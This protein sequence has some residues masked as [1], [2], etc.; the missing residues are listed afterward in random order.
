MIL[1]GTVCMEKKINFIFQR[2]DWESR[3]THYK[4]PVISR[5]KYD[6]VLADVISF[7]LRLELCFLWG[8]PLC[9]IS[10]RRAVNSNGIEKILVMGNIATFFR[11]ELSLIKCSS[12]TYRLIV[13]QNVESVVCHQFHW[14]F[15]VNLI[16]PIVFFIGCVALVI[17]PIIG[18]PKDTGETIVYSLLFYFLKQN[19]F[20]SS[21]KA[22][23]IQIGI[24]HL[25]FLPSMCKNHT[26]SV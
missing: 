6:L 7:Q 10:I 21:F 15:Q 16:Y 1:F 24:I 22:M 14:V 13:E 19:L 8:L 4:T 17:I 12:F 23:R 18:S 20:D 26:Y 25:H 3:I 5:I 2:S 11:I 9:A